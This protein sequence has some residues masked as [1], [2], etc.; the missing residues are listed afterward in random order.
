MNLRGKVSWF[1]GPADTTGVTASE[2]LAFIYEYSMAPHLFLPKQP[3]GTTGLARRLNPDVFYIACRWSYDAPDQSKTDLLEH[4]A[5]VRAPKT[6]REFVA[7]PADW[8]PNANTDRVA[9]ISSGLM[10]ALGIQTDDEVEI[11]Y[12]YS[13]Q[14]EIA[15]PYPRIVISSGHGKYVR[16]ASGAMDEVDE[17]R[18][19]VDHLADELE[20]R[21]V[22]VTVFHDDQS[23]S[24]S[25]NLNRI[26]SAHNSAGAHDLDVSVHFNAF[27]TQA[28]GVEVLWKT[29]K[30]LASKVSSAIAKAGKLTDRGQKERHDLAFLNGTHAKAILIET[31]FC[32]NVSDT[33]LYHTNFDAITTA[34]ADVLGGERQDETAPPPTQ[35]DLA[36]VDIQISGNVIVTV[37]GE[38]V[39]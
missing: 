6:G 29:Q 1:G 24:Q 7:Y 34:I 36:R 23:K 14:Q 2:G 26:V 16:G 17:A 10:T 33:N 30:D 4:M 37:N 22:D 13:D 21:G 3:P 12:P 18:K 19:L 38:T 32:D 25:E 20:L 5:L 27:N 39:E 9:D 28:H 8:G 35:P 15:M 11:I 31:A